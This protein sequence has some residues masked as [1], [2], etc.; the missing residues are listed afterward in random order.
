[1]HSYGT[2]AVAV[3]GGDD[4]AA[5]T[6]AGGGETRGAEN[7][8]AHDVNVDDENGADVAVEHA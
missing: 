8:S 2:L 5:G 6:T 3:R 4:G 7:A 1:M